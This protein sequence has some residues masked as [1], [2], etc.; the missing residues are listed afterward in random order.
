M[1]KSLIAHWTWV[2]ERV[3]STV[4]VEGDDYGYYETAVRE[5]NGR[6]RVKE[7]GMELPIE[8]EAFHFAT[9]EMIGR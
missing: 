7:W 9:V 2:G 6:I 1:M 8:A 5:A 3:V 4:W